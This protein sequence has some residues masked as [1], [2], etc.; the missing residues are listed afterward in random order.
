MKLKIATYNIHKGV[1]AFGRKARIHGLKEAISL[2]DADLVFLQEVQG[3]HD[4][5]AE[6]HTRWPEMGQDAFIAG[7][8]HEVAYGMN[9]VYQHG[10]HGNALLSRFAISSSYNHD[11]S[12]HAYEQRGILHVVIRLGSL[13]VHCFVIHLGLF[14]TSRRRQVQALI[15]EIQSNLPADAPLIIAGDFNDWSKGLSQT[16]YQELGV[17]EAFDGE[18]AQSGSLLSLSGM[19]GLMPQPRFKHA[20]TFPVE[21]PCLCLDR[22]YLRGFEVEQ[23]KVLRG[24]PW[25]TLSDHLPILVTLDFSS[26]I[27]AAMAA[28]ASSA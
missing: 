19:R 20:H 28:K 21:M 9:A 1:S 25:T 6:N 13:D 11:V 17:R 18:R 27:A 10:H 7:D 26:A 8:T 23:A 5:H 2:L 14:A 15:K 12:D 4:Y 3:Q 22:V 16:L 24:A